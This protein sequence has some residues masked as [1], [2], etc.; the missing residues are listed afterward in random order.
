M[1]TVNSIIK[2]IEDKMN[3][4]FE[5]NGLPR[6]FKFDWNRSQHRFRLQEKINRQLE[7]ISQIEEILNNK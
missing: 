3:D 1:K 5:R 6:S 4:T 7:K 2:E